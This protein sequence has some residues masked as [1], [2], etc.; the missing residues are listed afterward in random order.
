MGKT[1][2]NGADTKPKKSGVYSVR[3][4][5]EAAH[6]EQDKEATSVRGFAFYSAMNRRWAGTRP[7]VKDALASADTASPRYHTAQ[8]KEWCRA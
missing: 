4:T 1:K 6:C 8:D 2:W 5:V 7:T 3:H